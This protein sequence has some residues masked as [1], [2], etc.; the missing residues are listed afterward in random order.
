MRKQE[1]SRRGGGAGR[2]GEEKDVEEVEVEICT[3]ER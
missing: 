3:G 2:C 1:S